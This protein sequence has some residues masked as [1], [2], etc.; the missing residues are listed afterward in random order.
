M[1]A[2]ICFVLAVVAVLACTPRSERG[3]ALGSMLA[4]GTVIWL[5]VRI[6][7]HSILGSIFGN[8]AALAWEYHAEILLAFAAAVVLIVPVVMIYVGVCD[9]LEARATARK[10]RAQRSRRGIGFTLRSEHPWRWAMDEDGSDSPGFWFR[11]EK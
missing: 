9:Q 3:L 1:G 4:V 2:V 11:K 7:L 6:S 8:L 10:I 5:A